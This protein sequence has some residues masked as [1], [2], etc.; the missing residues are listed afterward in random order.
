MNGRERHRGRPKQNHPDRKPQ[1]KQE[2]KPS[3]HTRYGNV[4]SN[5]STTALLGFQDYEALIPETLKK[6]VVNGTVAY[7]SQVRLCFFAARFFRSK[8]HESRKHMSK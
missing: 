4:R 1:K 7:A 5:T 3:K 6:S 8:I 2:Q